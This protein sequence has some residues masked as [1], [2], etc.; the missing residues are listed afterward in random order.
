MGLLCQGDPGRRRRTGRVGLIVTARVPH[1]PERMLKR[2]EYDRTRAVKPSRRWYKLKAWKEKAARQ[3]ADEPFCRR[4][5]QLT[6]SRTVAAEIADHVEPHR[7]DYQAFWFGELQSLCGPCHSGPKQAE[8][9]RGYR[10]GAA[11]DGWPADPRHP[12]NRGGPL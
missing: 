6:P 5:D 8:E 11:D 1:T 12:F 4:C 10:V 9:V 2:R 7:E 3:L